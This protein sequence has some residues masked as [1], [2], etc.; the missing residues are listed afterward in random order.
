MQKNIIGALALG[1]LS[2]SALAQSS[3]TVYG[4]ALSLIHI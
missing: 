3:V 1:L 4:V 2:S